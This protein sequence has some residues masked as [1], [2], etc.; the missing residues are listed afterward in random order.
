MEEH[1]KTKFIYPIFLFWLLIFLFFSFFLLVIESKIIYD[2]FIG[3]SSVE[4]LKAFFGV[5]LLFGFFSL[6]S[7]HMTLLLRYGLMIQKDRII[8]INYLSFQKTDIT[9][10]IKGYSRTDFGKVS[11]SKKL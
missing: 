2:L 7:G 5:T 1:F 9:D 3:K 11:T 8:L 4:D 6:S 10:L